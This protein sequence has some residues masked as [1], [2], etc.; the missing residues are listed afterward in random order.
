MAYGKQNVKKLETF[1]KPILSKS[2]KHFEFVILHAYELIHKLV[3]N[4]ISPC[5]NISI[6]IKL[7]DNV[8]HIMKK[9]P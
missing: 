5:C 4:F 8:V 9:R 2:K 3:A 6:K 1:V 7:R